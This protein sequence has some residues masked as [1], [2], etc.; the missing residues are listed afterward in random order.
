MMP[1]SISEDAGIPRVFLANNIAVDV[2][3]ANASDITNHAAKYLKVSGMRL[4]SLKISHNSSQ[5]CAKAVRRDFVAFASPGSHC[6]DAGQNRNGLV[7][8]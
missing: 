2:I 3:V 1:M 6:S 5:A 8:L 7:W 4:N